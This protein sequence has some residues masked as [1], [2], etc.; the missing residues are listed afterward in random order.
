MGEQGLAR[1]VPPEGFRDEDSSSSTSATRARRA[2][3]RKCQPSRELQSVVLGR[4]SVP[5]AWWRHL[6]EPSQAAILSDCLM[7]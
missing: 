7:R 2:Q 4:R 1:G 6:S 3:R 5:P